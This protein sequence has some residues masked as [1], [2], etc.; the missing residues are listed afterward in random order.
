[1][2]VIFRTLKEYR[3]LWRVWVP[4]LVLALISV[5]VTLGLP[6]VEK[7]LIDG[8]LLPQRL[9]LLPQMVAI[10]GVLWLSGTVN[11]LISSTLSTYLGEQLTVQLRQRLFQH[12]TALSVGFSDGEHSGRTMSL[13]VNDVPRLVGLF[14]STVIT[15]VSSGLGLVV[16]IAVMFSLNTQ[17]AIVAGLTPVL[18]AGLATIVTRPL[19]AAV[20]RVQDKAAELTTR[21][22]EHLSG[23]REVV[24]FGQEHSQGIR[25]AAALAELLN[26]RM[27]VTLLQSGVQ[28][29]QMLFGLTLTLV[30]FGY[31]GYLVVQG[32]TTLGTLV[33]MRSLMSLVFSPA[34]RTFGLVSNAQA[35]QV[36]AERI[37]SF[38]DREPLVKE[39]PQ[40]RAPRTVD[41]AVTFDRVSFAYLPDRPV[42]HDISF[43]VRPGATVA[44]V[45][46]SGA[47]KST[48]AS[49]I[50][51]F[52]DPTHGR[53]LLDGTDLRELRLES[54][55]SQIGFVFQDTFLFD[56]SIRENVAFGRAN[57]SEQ[58]LIDALHA[59][60]AW[61]FIE[62]LPNGLDTDV[63]E[64]GVRLS[65]GQKQRLSIARALLRNPRILILDEPTSALD[66]R[67]E[68]LLQAAL[69]NLMRGRTSF[70]IAHRLATIQRADLILVVNDGRVVEQGT[71][72]E[73]LQREGLYQEL[74]DL[75]FGL[76]W[77][78][79][80][81]AA[82]ATAA[83]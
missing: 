21:I 77:R 57:A 59:A 65:E 39:N 79:G 31:G 64:R 35:A 28:G 80:A 70:V 2:T 75:Q 73:L 56:T 4:L 13:F 54:L 61:E 38:L 1:L 43:S 37:Y 16:G 8:V 30:L 20:R 68:H 74:F 60:N 49:L 15:A 53:V 24:A 11:Q 3:Q 27:R 19:K 44:L 36:S 71:H 14:T 9:D 51:R 22:Q 32:E 42:L 81:H 72:A 50:A 66:A 12:C 47:G 78:I 82:L 40:A 62:R 83:S 10:Y 23:I 45:G 63:G 76:G 7:Q 46:P 18:V 5:P 52:Y 41:G 6:L 29:G 33:A 58:E 48:L 55:R 26:L 69:Q 34:G 25:F 67:S 17:L